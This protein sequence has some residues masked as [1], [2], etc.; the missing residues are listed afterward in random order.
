MS[1]KFDEYGH[2]GENNPPV[3]D[4]RCAECTCKSGGTDCNWIRPF[5]EGERQR[6]KE[7]EKANSA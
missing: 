6:S 4:L 7:R 3:G 1:E 2:Y 5:D